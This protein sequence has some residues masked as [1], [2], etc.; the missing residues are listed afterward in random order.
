MIFHVK[1]EISVQTGLVL[2][3]IRLY[4]QSTGLRLHEG[5]ALSACGI[6]HESDIDLYYEQTGC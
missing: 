4:D 5:T 1:L 2:W 6:E 3:K